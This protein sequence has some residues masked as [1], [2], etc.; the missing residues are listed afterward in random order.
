[1]LGKVKGDRTE[2]FYRRP[3]PRDPTRTPEVAGWSS[4]EWKG[5]YK[6]FAPERMNSRSKFIEALLPT[7]L[8]YKARAKKAEAAPA[9]L[10]P[11]EKLEKELSLLT[12]QA[13]HKADEG[14]SSVELTAFYNDRIR[15]KLNVLG[16][17]Y[18][19]AGE[20]QEIGDE[21]FE[22]ITEH[23]QRKK[24]AAAAPA[25]AAPAKL[26]M[27]E[28]KAIVDKALD[29]L[30]AL[31]VYQNIKKGSNREQEVADWFWKA[32]MDHSRGPYKSKL[33]QRLK[34]YTDEKRGLS[35]PSAVF[36]ALNTYPLTTTH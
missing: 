10:S 3:Y 17:E 12:E 19:G 6:P 20:A 7:Q 35:Y 32:A 15:P 5:K 28:A 33:K 9:A 36:A 22:K 21:I 23:Y 18:L 13:V 4:S 8:P 11:K 25:P 1:M 14:A 30:K 31:P 29:V 16:A 26:S 2:D 27:E 34:Y 24:A